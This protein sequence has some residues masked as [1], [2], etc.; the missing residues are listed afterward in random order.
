[1]ADPL[2]PLVLSQ[3]NDRVTYVSSLLALKELKAVQGVFQQNKEVFAWTYS[4]MPGIH[5]SVASHKLNV[6]AS[7]RPVL[8]KVRCFHPDRQ[9]IIQREIEKL[10]TDGFI[11]EVEYL[12][13]LENVVVVPKKWR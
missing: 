6:M 1:M 4:D 5:P 7:S 11:K 2:L 13:W 10:V 3:D 9:K 8:Q 12:E